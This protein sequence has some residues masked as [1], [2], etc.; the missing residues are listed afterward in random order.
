MR[1][2]T[3]RDKARAATAATRI[4]RC[5]GSSSTAAST[6][7]RAASSA[8]RTAPSGTPGK[9][10]GLGRDWTIF[11]LIEG[12]VKFDQDGRR[13]NVVPLAEAAAR[14]LIRVESRSG[15]AP[16]R[17]VRDG[18]AHVRRSGDDLRARAATAATAA[19]ASAARSTSPRAAPTAATAATAGS[20]ILRA[21][22]G[23]TNL[24]HL[25][26]AAALEGRPRRARPGLRLHR[27]GRPRTWSSRSPPARSSA[28]ATAATSSAT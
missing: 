21:V 2:L 16:D 6:P 11:S 20:V 1:W 27:P 19:S 10:V 23:L 4:R 7:S 28:T 12:T 3:R 18:V 14:G 8:A 26:H 24:A 17:A 13:I 5:W 9:N 15:R 25:S 22:E